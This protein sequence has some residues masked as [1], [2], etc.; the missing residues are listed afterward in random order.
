LNVTVA[1]LVGLTV[2]V[3]MRIVGILLVAALMVLPVIAASRLAR[4]MRGSFGLSLA[5]GLASVWIGLTASYYGNLAA[6]GAI[7]LVA[8]AFVLAATAARSFRPA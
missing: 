1:A 6:G 7:V 5:F 3:S 2:A 4:S 8:A